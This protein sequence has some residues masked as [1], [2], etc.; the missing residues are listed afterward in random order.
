[1]SIGCAA[2]E[3]GCAEERGRKAT[4]ASGGRREAFFQTR[5]KNE[6]R[7]ASLPTTKN[8]DSLLSFSRFRN[9]PTMASVA[10]K[11]RFWALPCASLRVVIDR[12]SHS[13]FS[14]PEKHNRNSTPHRRCRQRRFRQRRRS[15]L[16]DLPPAFP[17]LRPPPLLLYAPGSLLRRRVLPPCARRR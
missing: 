2:E 11:V 17:A 5:R 15:P 12:S 4:D 10:L 1:M 16:P 13:S 6:Q 9:Q 14:L 8:F 3:R 7:C